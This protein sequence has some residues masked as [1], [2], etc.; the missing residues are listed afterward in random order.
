MWLLAL[1]T[2]GRAAS[3]AIFDDDR[4]AALVSRP[5]DE[6]HSIRLFR[7]IESALQ[8]VKLRISDVDVYAVANGPGAFTALRVGLTAVK[9]FAEMYG[10]PVVAVSVLEAVCQHARAEGLLAPVVDAY[11]GQVFGGLYEKKGSEIV[12]RG[13]ERVL[14]LKE[15][16]AVVSRDA[17]DARAATLISPSLLRLEP[18]LAGSPLAG[19]H[20]EAAPSILAD[21]VGRR[22]RA[23]L[24]RGEVS[25]A[26]H[27]DANYVRRSDAE[28][29][30][31]PK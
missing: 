12:A 5:G 20:R 21:A 29:L 31:K 6:Q 4:M 7:E 19:I 9:S 15:F 8:Q 27:L 25:N 18:E 22:A 23:K 3:V 26:V 14:R 17:V 10:K 1:D 30:W 2:S 28:L 16:L 11:R 13:P 24:A